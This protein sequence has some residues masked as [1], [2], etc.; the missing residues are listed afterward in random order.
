M[1]RILILLCLLAGCSTLAPSRVWDPHSEV[2]TGSSASLIAG[3]APN[4]QVTLRAIVTRSAKGTAHGLG[5]IV[6]RRDLNY[7]KITAL[8]SFGK[9]LPYRKL[10][11]HRIGTLRAEIGV[12]PLTPSLFRTFA[13]TGIQ[14]R[15]YGKRGQYDVQ[16][17]AR[18]FREAL[19]QSARRNGPT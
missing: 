19:A 3:R 2:L 7:P 14:F 16:A 9:A 6:A 1:A 13:D 5:V 4:A 8:K 15:I 17:P 10:D 11:R 18:L 12:I